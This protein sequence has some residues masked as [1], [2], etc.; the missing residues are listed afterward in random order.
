M[1]TLQTNTAKIQ[2]ILLMKLITKTGSHADINQYFTV[3]L[4]IH[5]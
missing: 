5:Q 2:N 1:E 3:L 4:P